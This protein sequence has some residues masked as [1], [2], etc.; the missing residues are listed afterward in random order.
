MMK[1]KFKRLIV[2]PEAFLMI[3]QN[4]TSWKVEV[5]VPQGARFR[6]CSLDPYA[7][8]INIFVEHESFPDVEI[9]T[10]APIL[11]TEFVKVR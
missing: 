9:G 2:N 4:D 8:V 10:V 5:G 11:P 7:L 1:A 3:M 6:G